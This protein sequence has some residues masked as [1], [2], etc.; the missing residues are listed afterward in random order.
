MPSKDTHNSSKTTQLQCQSIQSDKRV[1]KGKGM[2]GLTIVRHLLESKENW[3]TISAKSD[4]QFPGVFDFEKRTS[5]VVY[6]MMTAE[7]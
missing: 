2:H 5:D 4:Y 3:N 7:N 6:C 1:R